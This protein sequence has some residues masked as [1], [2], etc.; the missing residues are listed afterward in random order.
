MEKLNKQQ[1]AEKK[2]AEERVK[3]FGEEVKKLSEKYRV[4]IRG[5]LDYRREGVVPML[6]F[7]DVKKQYEAMTAQAKA[8]EAEKAKASPV[9][10][11]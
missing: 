4:D 11:V 1:R 10:K 5:S 8:M 3:E 9:L 6:V 2:D 7:V